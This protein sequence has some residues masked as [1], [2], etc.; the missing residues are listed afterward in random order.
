MRSDCR[1]RSERFGARP[2][3]LSALLALAVAS[4]PAVSYAQQAAPPAH[5]GAQV[6]GE[7]AADGQPAEGEHTEG[8]L[9]LVA[10]LVNFAALVGLLAYFLKTPLAA[11]LASRAGEIRQDLVAAADMRRQATE[12]LAHI[13]EKVRSLPGELE[14]LKTRGAEDLGA[15]QARIAQAVAAERQRLLDHTR[16]EIEMRLR[17][18]R[19]E[20]V[21]YAAE[22]A[23]RVAEHR[24]KTT[25]T[26][27]DQL[28]LMDRYTT[29]L[30]N[31]R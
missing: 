25:I 11:Y 28:R 12:Q 14:A 21:Q 18:A 27:E 10:K 6:S 9:P 23:V 30:E 15:E 20:L 1:H 22:L 26:P 17:I 5:A 2:L 19:R 8:L 13:E 4:A 3:L 16:R 31:V 7:R 24:V 29:Q